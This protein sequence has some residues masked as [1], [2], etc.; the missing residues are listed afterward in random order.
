MAKAAPASPPPAPPASAPAQS[1]S[2]HAGLLCAM[3]LI[4]VFVALAIPLWLIGA[5]PTRVAGDQNLYHLPAIQRFATDW[6]AVD[7][8]DYLS[9]TTPGYHLALAAIARYVSDQTIVLQL[10]GSLFT[11]G[12]LGLLGVAMARRAPPAPGPRGVPWAAIAFALPVVASQYVLTSGVWLLPDN[13]AWWGVLA[14]LLIALSGRTDGRA[15]LLAGI[16][17]TLLVFVRQ[18]H[19]WTAGV[20]ALAWWLGRPE[21]IDDALGHPPLSGRD[22]RR[23]LTTPGARAR[24]A[25]LAVLAALPAVALLAAFVVL[26]KGLTPPQFQGVLRGGNPATPAFVLALLG[27]YGV[28]FAPVLWRPLQALLLTRPLTLLAFGAGAVL[29][30]LASP[31]TRDPDAGRG[32]ALWEMAGA[33]PTLGGRTSVLILALAVAGMVALVALLC[34]CNR[35]D[36]WLL[37]AAILGFTAAQSAS[38]MCWQRYIEPLLLI[39][40]ALGCARVH[41]RFEPAGRGELAARLMGPL[42]LAAVLLGVMGMVV[43]RG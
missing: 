23:L 3:T 18:N 40:M 2:P 9:A 22:V 30:A 32:G 37:L 7:L 12:L 27:V 38:A 6:P 16:V 41:A 19:I 42:A 29:I 33:L 14:V 20:L 34:G 17:L 10:A 4:A 26:W 43:I 8:R 25:A 21:P 31:T 24:R 36:R 1:A 11:L 28:F 15:L 5:M 13:A 39:V 35:R